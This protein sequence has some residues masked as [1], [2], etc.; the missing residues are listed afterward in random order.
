MNLYMPYLF[1]L[2]LLLAYTLTLNYEN[3]CKCSD[4]VNESNCNENTGACVWN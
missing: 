1:S 3:N 2:S 4:L